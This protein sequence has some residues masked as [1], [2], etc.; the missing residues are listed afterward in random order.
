MIWDFGKLLGSFK[1][2]TST[3]L[4]SHFTCRYLFSKMKA[5]IHTKTIIQMSIVESFVVLKNWK[6]TC[7]LTTKWINTL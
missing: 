5:Y 6:H 4:P 1:K 3:K 2:Y 7:L